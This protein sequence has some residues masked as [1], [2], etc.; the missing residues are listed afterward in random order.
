MHC[1]CSISTTCHENSFLTYK[2]GNSAHAVAIPI[3]KLHKSWL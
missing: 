3:K 2:R 1:I